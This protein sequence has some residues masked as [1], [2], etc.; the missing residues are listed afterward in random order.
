MEGDGVYS[1]VLGRMII[2]FPVIE[3]R[4]LWKGQIENWKVQK[5]GR[6]II[7][8]MGRRACSVPGDLHAKSHLFFYNNAARKLLHFIDEK[9]E[10]ER[11]SVTC[12]GSSDQLK[13]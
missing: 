13:I 8:K 2:T 11:C 4:S 12:P 6:K 3:G 9:T 7:M 1:P 5:E 10:T